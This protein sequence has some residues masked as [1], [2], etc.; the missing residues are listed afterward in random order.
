MNSSPENVLLSPCDGKILRIVNHKHALQ[1]AIFLNIHNI[2]VQYAPI[3]GQIIS[4]LHK[5]GEFVPAYMFQKSQYN[6]RIETVIESKLGSITVVQI[7]GQLARR[8][9]SFHIKGNTIKRGDPLGLIKFGSRVDLWIPVTS[10]P[11]VMVKEGEYV[12]IGKYIA[13]LNQ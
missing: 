9:I 1:I 2:H 8:I 12:Q 4:I 3:S 7:A 6:E 13:I 5:R 11:Q 10:K